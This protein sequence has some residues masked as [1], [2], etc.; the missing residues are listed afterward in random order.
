MEATQPVNAGSRIRLLLALVLVLSVGV[1][2]A[3][4]EA[5]TSTSVTTPT[6]WRNPTNALDSRVQGTSS[7]SGPCNAM[8]CSLRTEL[9][10][11]AP[12]WRT[13]ASRNSAGVVRACMLNGNTTWYRTSIRA[14]YFST[15]STSVGLTVQTA[16][17]T[18]TLPHGKWYYTTKTSASARRSC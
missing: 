12:Y 6:N 14:G 10:Y 2:G 11:L 17:G 18:V 9:Q 5:A 8:Q 16:G 13:A 7:A 3:P 15:A 1:Y 4:V